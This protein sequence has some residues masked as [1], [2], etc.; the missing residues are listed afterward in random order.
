MPLIVGRE[1]SLKALEYSLVSSHLLVVV[2]QR[3]LTQGDPEID[4]LFT[5]GTLCKIESISDSDSPQRQAMVTGIARYHIEKCEISTGG[6]LF[7]RG[8][9]MPDVLS[10]DHLRNEALFQSLKDAAREII[11]LLPGSTEPL[12][13]LIERVDDP[14]YLCN[15]CSAY[16]NLG[17]FQKQELLETSQI[18]R[19]MEILLISIRKERE[20]LDI[21]KEIREKMSE[22]M[23]KAQRE[24]LLREQ[25]RTIRTELG[26]EG[27]EN[28]TDELEQK[29]KE[30]NLS[31]EAAKQ[32][33]EEL[34]RLKNLPSSSAEYHVI[35]TYLEWIAALP[36]KTAP[37]TP[38]NLV[39]ARAIL[40][41]DHFGL[42]DVKKRILQFLAVAKLKNDLHGPIL[43]LLGPPGVGK[44]S[45]G[46]SIAR[47]L[48]RKFIRAS[49]GGVRDEA[50]IR[51]HRRTYVGAMPGRIIQS[52]KRVQTLNPLILLDEIDKLRTD[53][54]G[55]PSS[56]MLEVLDPEQN[57]TFIDHYLDIPYDLSRV[58]FITTAN[59]TDTI[60][61]ALKDRME[62]IEI[63]GYTSL[64]KLQIAKHF[65]I[66]KLLME[67][68]LKDDQIEFPDDMILKI[69]SHYTREAG[70]RELERKLAALCRIAAE[71]IVYQNM[72]SSL[73]P[74]DPLEEPSEPLS[75]V[76]IPTALNLKELLGPEQFIPETGELTMKPGVA[77]GLAWTPHGGDLL[78]IESKAMATGKGNLILTGQLGEVMRESAQIAVSLARTISPS[79]LQR[80]FDFS[81]QDIHI[82]VPA[83]SIPKDG[84]SAGVSILSSL[85]SLILDQ[86]LD[87]MLAMTGEITLRGAVLPVGGI[88]EKVLAAHRAGLS[89]VL[90]PKKN[91]PD[92]PSIPEEIRNSL[93]FIWVDTVEDLLKELIHEEP[94]PTLKTGT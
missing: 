69:I 92:F 13:K 54:H 62:I 55:D 40:N 91:Q 93:K 1:R 27:S 14:S 52:I 61:P 57:G 75:S 29:L 7:A 89:R 80:A 20:I 64:E 21:Q 32:A 18:E 59:V 88:K 36:W 77:M 26:E 4:D 53:F 41:E 23:N 24:A 72:N 3:V 35:R 9:I 46:H 65:L 38:I 2:T 76:I 15:I 48:G 12:V 94:I 63:H 85:A 33:N 34:K 73:D 10:S 82:H 84:P 58:F 28:A 87:P 42:E 83:G 5:V 22:R 78:F 51:G 70:V 81:S 45:L 44:T 90:L 49:L 56:A 17:L 86:P 68:G 47:A 79:L 19:R 16:L 74:L 71:T 6:Y 37:D 11:G 60:P 31:A 39:R 30:A 25:L 50:E 66:P 67:H 43:C 8:E